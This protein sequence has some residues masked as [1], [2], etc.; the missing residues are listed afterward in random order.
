L[1]K[2]RYRLIAKEQQRLGD[3]LQAIE[4]LKGA[5][6]REVDVIR[7]YHIRRLAPLMAHKLWM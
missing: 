5:G 1:D 2:W 3:L 6:F 4:T 7:A